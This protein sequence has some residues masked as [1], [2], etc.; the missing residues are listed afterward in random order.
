MLSYYHSYNHTTILSFPLVSLSCTFP[1]QKPI[2]DVVLSPLLLPKSG[3]IYHQVSPSL[4]SFKRHRKTHY[5][6]SP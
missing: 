4:D 1:G 2:L 3:T 5:F 6:T